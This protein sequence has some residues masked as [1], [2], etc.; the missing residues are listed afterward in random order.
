MKFKMKSKLTKLIVFVVIHLQV[1]SASNVSNHLVKKYK[2]YCESNRYSCLKLNMLME[3]RKMNRN[4]YYPL[5]EDVWLEQINKNVS[6]LDDTDN[7]KQLKLNK[8]NIK[9][10][11]IISELNDVFKTHSL[12]MNVVPGKDLEIYRSNADGKFNLKL[13]GDSA[14]YPYY[15]VHSPSTKSGGN[16]YTNFFCFALHRLCM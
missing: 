5:T 6:A 13:Q 12:F 4:K 3:I 2:T 7:L 11:K 9:L 14:R 8:S 10:N 16:F 15:V 1:Y